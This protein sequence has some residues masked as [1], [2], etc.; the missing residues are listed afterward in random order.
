V[1]VADICKYSTFSAGRFF[2][3]YE[4]YC[5]EEMKNNEKD[6]NMTRM[7]DIRNGTKSLV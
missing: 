6:G 7:A 4:Y 3:F 1:K 5:D 2:F